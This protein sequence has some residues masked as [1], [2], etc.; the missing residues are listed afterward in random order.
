MNYKYIY[1]DSNWSL[2]LSEASIYFIHLL[3]STFGISPYQALR[4]KPKNKSTS[5]KWQ[6]F[7]FHSS[8][9]LSF[10]RSAKDRSRQA[11]PLPSSQVIENRFL[12]WKWKTKNFP[13]TPITP[14]TPSRL[15]L[16]GYS[17]PLRPPASLQDSKGW[18]DLL[19][20]SLNLLPTSYIA[21]DPLSPL[22][23]HSDDSSKLPL[24]SF[25]CSLFQSPV[26]PGSFHVHLS[27][28][29]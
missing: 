8:C 3:A 5:Q 19:S 17:P 4:Q 6:N 23:S 12:V 26:C 13:Q 25:Q 18:G 10:T 24:E 27:L 1:I 28:S 7:H 14:P 2:L 22:P 15:H 20:C 9:L 11:Q 29:L 16:P 21:Y